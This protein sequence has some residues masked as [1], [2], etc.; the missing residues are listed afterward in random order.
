MCRFLPSRHV[1]GIEQDHPHSVKE[2]IGKRLIVFLAFNFVN[3]GFV[4]VVGKNIRGKY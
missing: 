3:P 2:V 4:R 1:E